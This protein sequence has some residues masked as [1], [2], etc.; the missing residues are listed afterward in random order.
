[1]SSLKEEEEI[2]VRENPTSPAGKI[3]QCYSPSA[4][5]LSPFL[6]ESVKHGPH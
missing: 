4:F 2:E 1:M 5:N 6:L 3:I